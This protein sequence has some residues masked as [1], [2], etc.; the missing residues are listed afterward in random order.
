MGTVRGAVTDDGRRR[1]QRV[2]ARAT[3]S[4]APL[5]SLLIHPHI[6]SSLIS[7]PFPRTRLRDLSVTHPSSSIGQ[8]ASARNALA[9]R[10]R[11]PRPSDPPVTADA[12]SHRPRSRSTH[13]NQRHCPD[14]SS[15]NDETRPPEPRVR[16][17]D[18]HN[19][20]QRHRDHATTGSTAPSQRI[21][22]A[23]H[24]DRIAEKRERCA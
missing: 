24:I 2:P 1:G 9:V 20:Q 5:P 15:N 19:D 23:P 18:Q 6:H 22:S 17:W 13:T 21:C 16:N 11:P 14:Y 7:S 12:A 4:I 3:R 10:V 8:W